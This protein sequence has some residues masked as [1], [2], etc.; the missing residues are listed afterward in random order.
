M[1]TKKIQMNTKN[2]LSENE[3]SSDISRNSGASSGVIDGSMN[4]ADNVVLGAKQGHGFAAEKANHL[5][6]V[7]TGKDAEIVGGDN[8]R[9]GADRL[10]NGIQIQTKYC[11]SGKA[12]IDAC[13][14]NGSFRYISSDGTPMQIEVPSDMYDD[15][16][17]VAQAEIDAG[18]IPGV[19]DAKDIVRSGHYTYE[20]AK[21]IARFGTIESLT[22]DAV[23]GLK[24][25]G[26]AMGISSA[27]SFAVAMWNGKDWKVA[28]ENACFDG[29][30]VG[31]IAW[32]GSILT[33]QLGRTG[34]EQSLRRTTDWVVKQMGAKASAWI[35]NGLRSGSKIYGASAA[36]YVS[37]LLRGNVVAGIATTV[38]LSV[39]DFIR[40][41]DGKVSGTQVFKNITKT[42]SAVAGGTAG[43]MGGAAAGA[44]LGSIIPILGTAAGGIL[45]GVLGGIVGGGSASAVA[46]G[47]LDHY[48]EDDAKEMLRK[49]EVAFG[50][51]AEDYLLTEA[52]AKSV[53]KEFQALDVP[54]LLHEMYASNNPSNFAKKVLRPFVE[55]RAES[56]K[57][58]KLP[59]DAELIKATGI[60]I[61]KLSDEN[62][63]GAQSID[64][65]GSYLED[66]EMAQPENT[67][68]VQNTKKL[69]ELNDFIFDYEQHLNDN[70]SVFIGIALVKDK[71]AKK[72]R[73]AIKSYAHT[74]D[75]YSPEPW[76]S[77]VVLVDA[78]ALGSAS[79]GFYITDDEIYAKPA[80]DPRYIIKIKDIKTIR[81]H[82]DDCKISING[83]HLEYVLSSLTP[84][85]KIIVKC[86]NKYI[87]QFSDSD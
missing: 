77:L 20:Q 40:L 41:F 42:G 3:K 48:I 56:R 84:K 49:I 22:Y 59:T 43:Y 5:H 11:S 45:G 2:N 9:N 34:I 72:V 8:A 7:L 10:V 67:A 78:T 83:K 38:V 44:A 55:E 26:T 62:Q 85:M 53:I 73:K 14:E 82:E 37:K 39:D 68:A 33:A 69:R 66:A 46:S 75:E 28:L 87:E 76:G 6:D 30:S 36:N 29:I 15:A 13:F 4:Y 60:I 18:R 81:V 21:N 47:V 58:I 71:G 25:A 74:K 12:C 32:I 80:Y 61:D 57:H 16:L 79:D 35:A 51:L 27:I 23:N 86:I 1:S 52:E 70:S 54:N 19:T 63:E 31:G 17:K 64:K 24:L 65:Q 50:Q